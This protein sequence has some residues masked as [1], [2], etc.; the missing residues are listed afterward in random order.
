[1]I[2]MDAKER[3]R[4]RVIEAVREKRLRQGEAA[5]RLGLSVRQVKRLVRAH[6]QAGAL[7]LISKRRGQPSRRRIG[8]AERSQVLACVRQHYADFGPTLA[9]EYLKAHHGFTRSVETLRQWMLG[10]DLWVAKRAR[11]KRAFQLR[12]RRAGVGELVQIDG[13]PHA[14]LED[15]GPRCTLILFVDDA[16]GRLRYARFEPV[17]TTRAYL[18]GL[19]TYVSACGRPVAFYSDRH[20]I[21]RKHDPEDP[22]PTQF[23]RAVRALDIAP[24]LALSPQAKG[25]VERAFQTLQDRLVKALRL[26]RIDTLEAANVLLPR[27]IAHYNARF[28]KAPRCPEDAHRRLNVSAEQLVWITSEQHTRTLSKSLS[29]QYRGRLL[30]I[31]TQGA[32]A[33]HLRG[34]RITVC[35]DGTS[36]SIVLLHQGK[37]LSYRVFARHDLPARIADD[38]TVDAHVEAAR[39]RQVSAPLTPAANHPWR[40]PF[41]PSTAGPPSP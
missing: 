37:A 31:Q 6:R 38:K 14:W 25:R 19:R 5:A 32:P 24:I 28:A 21:F 39:R 13:S 23:E 1:M 41:N 29:C 16:S 26:A 8:E 9:A 15:R 12:E 35:D 20:S 17:E 10:D 3:D 7:G 11:S 2:T 33:Y 40:K 34:A 36:E 18:R 27:F 4:L 22:E 30:L